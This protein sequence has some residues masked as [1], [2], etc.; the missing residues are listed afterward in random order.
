MTERM[1][2]QRVA[3]KKVG[4]RGSRAEMLNNSPVVVRDP[5]SDIVKEPLRDNSK[6]SIGHKVIVKP[7]NL[8]GNSKTLG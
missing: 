5:E 8:R 3:I 6:L 4:S 1:Q 2:R 7:T